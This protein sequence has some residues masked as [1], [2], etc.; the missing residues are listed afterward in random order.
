[1]HTA[2][3]Q[4]LEV[5]GGPGTRLVSFIIVTRQPSSFNNCVTISPCLDCVE[6]H[7]YH[8]P[9]LK[10]D[11]NSPIL[12]F[13]FS[14]HLSLSKKKKTN[15]I[16]FPDCHGFEAKDP[17]QLRDFYLDCDGFITDVFHSHIEGDEALMNESGP[18]QCFIVQ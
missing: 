16:S 4:K 17:Q 5:G 8:L 12:H 18:G 10:R 7:A 9:W 13:K 3:N 6:V 1:M 14:I 15:I 11:S 2:T